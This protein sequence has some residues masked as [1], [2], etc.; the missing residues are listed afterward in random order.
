MCREENSVSK[1]HSSFVTIFCIWCM[2][3]R[4]SYMKLTRATNLMQQLWFIIINISTCLGHLYAHLQE[5]RLCA[6]AY[7]VQHCKRQLGISG[8]FIL[9]CSSCCVLVALG[10]AV[11]WVNQQSH[12]TT[13]NIEWN[14][15]LTPNYLLQCQTQYAAAHNMYSWR[16]AYRCPQHLDIFMIINHN[17]CI[18]LVTLVIFFKIYC[19]DFC[20]NHEV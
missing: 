17:C 7:G 2:C 8:W 13:N 10:Y 14:Q 6:A 3:D 18:K 20:M 16:W 9:C 1:Q 4:A 5:F 15:P 19:Y 12:N 11:C